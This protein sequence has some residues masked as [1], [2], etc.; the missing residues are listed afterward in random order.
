MLVGVFLNCL[1]APVGF[2]YHFC[3]IIFTDLCTSSMPY[4]KGRKRDLGS[5]YFSKKVSEC[6]VHAQLLGRE[7]S[8]WTKSD[9]GNVEPEAKVVL[10]CMS[11][12]Q[13]LWFSH[14]EMILI[15]MWCWLH[16]PGFFFRQSGVGWLALSPS[17]GQMSGTE[18]PRKDLKKWLKISLCCVQLL[19]SYQE[20]IN[21]YLC[22]VSQM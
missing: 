5:L 14:D 8:F 10:L 2:F 18:K 7:G 4:H 16:N 22:I 13:S 11:A 9:C 20:C 1:K 3:A 19:V 21:F 6:E 12:K 15:C 17:E